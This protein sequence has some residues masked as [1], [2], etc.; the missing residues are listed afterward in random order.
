MKKVINTKT[1]IYSYIVHLKYFKD[2]EQEGYLVTVPA[3][4]GCS[5]WGKTYEEAISRAEECIQG[6]LEALTKAGQPIPEE[7]RP[8]MPIEALIRINSS[9]L[10]TS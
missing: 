5:T 3:L 2:G 4:R 8:R 7:P 9:T 10:V 6:F 1:R